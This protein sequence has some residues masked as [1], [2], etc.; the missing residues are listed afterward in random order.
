MTKPGLILRCGCE[1]PFEDGAEVICPTHG[2]Q[3][4]AR[5][6]RMPKPRIKGVAFGPLVQTCDLAPFTGRIAGSEQ[7]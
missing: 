3:G 2:V 7:K 4:V 6:V 1:I 5:T